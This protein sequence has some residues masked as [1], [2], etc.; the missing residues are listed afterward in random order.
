MNWY[1]EISNILEELKKKKKIK[2]KEDDDK[3]EAIIRNEKKYI[4]DEIKEYRKKT[5]LEFLEFV[6]KK[7]P[8]LSK[9]FK[10]K[11]NIKDEWKKNPKKLILKL[12][13]NYHP[14]HLG[15]KT[16]TLEEKLNYRIYQ[17]IS[18]ELNSISSQIN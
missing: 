5:H 7:H 13:R 6:L 3:I 12:S 2:D 18:S 10:M 15:L 16:D 1:F 11:T 14:D 9:S 17:T 4:F 8:P